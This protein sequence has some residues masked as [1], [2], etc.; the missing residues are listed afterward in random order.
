M[1]AAGAIVAACAQLLSIDD[2]GYAAADDAAS[3]PTIGVDSGFD[4]GLDSPMDRSLASFTEDFGSAL[5]TSKWD[6]HQGIGYAVTV[7]SGQLQI[8]DTQLAS[9]WASITS[10]NW[11]DARNT[12]LSIHIASGGNAA[13]SGDTSNAWVWF[14]LRSP[15][16]AAVEMS[17][18]SGQLYAKAFVDGGATI[19]PF[20]PIA[21]A[22]VRFR[23][24]QGTI[25]WEYA[26]TATGP[27]TQ[28][29][30]QADPVPL[31]IV[32]IQIG[33]GAWPGS[34]GQVDFSDLRGAQAQ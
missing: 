26:R 2:V 6:L 11:Y 10:R 24:L 34:V 3:Q 16:G 7:A 14:Q 9:D 5:N 20:D 13:T 17:L 25:Y 15:S 29:A 33:A 27:W 22:W 18:K 31:D 32:F 19:V 30:A 28:L 21:M 12:A 4:A 8:A 23:E 1:V